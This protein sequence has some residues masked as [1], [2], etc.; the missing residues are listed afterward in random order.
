MADEDEET[1]QVS[2]EGVI[3]VVIYIHP[4]VNIHLPTYI[5]ALFQQLDLDGD[6]LLDKNDLRCAW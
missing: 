4:T 6:G 2:C 3:E 1:L 5:Q